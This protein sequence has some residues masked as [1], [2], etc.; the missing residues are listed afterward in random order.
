MLL[1]NR[2][3]IAAL[4]DLNEAAIAVEQAYQ[5][6][7]AGTVSLSPIGHLTFPEREADCHI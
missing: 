5:A 2:S 7:S 3:A 1:L 4:V 6:S